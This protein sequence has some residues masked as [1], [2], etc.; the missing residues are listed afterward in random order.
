MTTRGKIPNR[1]S[2]LKSIPFRNAV[3]LGGDR[4]PAAGDGVDGEPPN[5]AQ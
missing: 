5:S 1:P 4:V 3:F 2:A